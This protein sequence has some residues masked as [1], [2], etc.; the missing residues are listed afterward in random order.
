MS[1]RIPQVVFK[2]AYPLDR[3][4]RQLFKRKDLEGYPSKKRVNKEVQIWRELWSEIN[5]D[6]SVIKKIIDITGITYPRDIEVFVIGGGLGA[7]STPLILPVMS[8]EGQGRDKRTELV[9]HELLHRFAG[10]REAVPC[11]GNYW[12]KVREKWVDESKL[13]QNH[14]II[15]ALLIRILGDL[16]PDIDV[17]DT[18]YK[19]ATDYFR[20]L[21]I[22]REEGPDEIIAEFRELSQDK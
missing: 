20:A 11:V 9:I 16:A 6:D 4:R 5:K 13:T 7:M 8:L 17:K 2:Y 19:E 15:Y 22:A 10:D 18:I 21:E 12:S 3:N 14:I 1:E